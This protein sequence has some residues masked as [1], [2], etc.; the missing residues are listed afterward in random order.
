MLA[1]IKRTGTQLSVGAMTLFLGAQSAFAA[2]GDDS[3]TLKVG[4]EDKAIE[5]VPLLGG[6]DNSL[7]D[8]I[9]KII[10]I[11]LI[12][13]G[14]L[15]VIYLIYGG[16]MYVTAGGDAEKA[17]KGRIAITNAIIGIIIIMLAL[18]LYN[19]VIGGATTGE[20]T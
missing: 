3:T 1:K 16:I 7:M 5:K 12:V 13:V 8:I 9:G 4:G 11:I 14:V 15:A 20:V 17:N 10:N 19:F 18:A 2:T 6:T